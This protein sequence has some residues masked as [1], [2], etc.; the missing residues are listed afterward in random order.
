MRRLYAGEDLVGSEA[1]DVL[2]GY[3]LLLVVGEV[4]ADPEMYFEGVKI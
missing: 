4:D 3:I 2:V 1:G